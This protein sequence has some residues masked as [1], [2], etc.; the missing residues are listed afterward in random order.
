MQAAAAVFFVFFLSRAPFSVL[1]Q[2]GGRQVLVIFFYYYFDVNGS[3][4]G[5]NL[6]ANP[7]LRCSSPLTWKCGAQ[8]C[9]TCVS[10]SLSLYIYIYMRAHTRQLSTSTSIDR[11][12]SNRRREFLSLTGAPSAARPSFSP[13]PTLNE[14]AATHKHFSE[15]SLFL[16]K[17]TLTL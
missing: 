12:V 3:Y 13:N 6:R 4:S 17:G 8:L 16:F 2:G 5:S 10:L 11:H 7:L 1:W 14:H 15:S 9:V